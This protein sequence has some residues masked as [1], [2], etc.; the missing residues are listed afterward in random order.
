LWQ[1]GA[2]S[3]ARAASRRGDERGEVVVVAPS[4]CLLGV[5]GMICVVS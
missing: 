2:V 3:A 5:L 4:A 1:S